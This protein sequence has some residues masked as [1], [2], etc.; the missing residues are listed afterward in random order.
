MERLK[1]S[2]EYWKKNSDVYKNVE[3]NYASVASS[4]NV[5]CFSMK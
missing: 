1:T 4:A 3:A 2:A 5:M